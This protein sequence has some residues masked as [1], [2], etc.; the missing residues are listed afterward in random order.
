MWLLAALAVLLAACAGGEPRIELVGRPQASVPVAGASQ[1]VLQLANSGDGRDRLVSVDTDAALGVEI[2]ETRIE[3][4]RASMGQLDEV[5]LYPGEVVRFRPGELHL[6]LVA[7]EA[8]VVEGGTFPLTLSFER[9]Q[10][11][12][13]EVTVVPLLDLAEGAFDDPEPTDTE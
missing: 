13:V 7:P 9:S 11:M 2:H 4:G 6:M 10:P 8:S 3:D 5:D 1:I 12:T